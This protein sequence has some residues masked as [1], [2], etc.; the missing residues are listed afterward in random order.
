[1]TLDRW[2]A[3]REP[4]PPARLA[5]RLRECLGT[6]LSASVDEA[7]ELLLAASE[8]LLRTLLAAECT[9]RETALD[10]LVADALVTYAFE[11]AGSR[12]ES[13]DGRARRA[14]REIS[15]I[16]LASDG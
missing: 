16:C 13:L 3:T 2:L 6:S 8:S 4:A 11:A 14:M 1:M 10:L 9:D 15:S 5:A 12:P 7:P